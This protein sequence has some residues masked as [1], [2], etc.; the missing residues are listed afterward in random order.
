M[1]SYLDSALAG[2][3]LHIDTESFDRK[4][5]KKEAAGIINRLGNVSAPW[6]TPYSADGEYE[7]L[8]IDTVRGVSLYELYEL[9]ALQGYSVKPGVSN[10][11]CE[12]SWLGQ[13]FYFMDFDCGLSPE[14]TISKFRHCGVEPAFWYRSPSWTAENNK[15]RLVFCDEEETT[16]KVER[17]RVMGVLFWIAGKTTEDELVADKCTFPGAHYYNGSTKGGEYFGDYVFDRKALLEL[18]CDECYDFMPKRC[19]YRDVASQSCSG[20]VASEMRAA[21]GS[22]DYEFSNS[23]N[24]T[25]EDRPRT[26]KQ[27]KNIDADLVMM[28]RFFNLRHWVE[29]EKRAEFVYA[30]YLEAVIRHGYIEGERLTRERISTMLE[31]LTD[32]ELYYIF[33][34]ANAK[35]EIALEEDGV[36]FPECRET[37]AERVNM[38]AEE[39]EII[40]IYECRNRNQRAD[41]RR[42]RKEE[43]DEF[44]RENA[45]LGAREI[46]M[47]LEDMF[48]DVLIGEKQIGRIIDKVDATVE[49]N[50]DSFEMDIFPQNTF[51]LSFSFAPA[52]ETNNSSEEDAVI[53]SALAGEDVLLSGGAGCGKTYLVTNILR[54][55]LADLGKS[56]VATATTGKGASLL[57]GG[58]TVHRL[59][60]IFEENTESMVVPTKL[61]LSLLDVDVVFVDEASMLK[62]KDFEYIQKV[63]N[64]LKQFYNHNIQLILV[65]DFMQ[66]PPVNDKYIFESSEFASWN[67]KVHYLTQI[68]R[69]DDRGFTDMLNS[70]RVA[71]ELCWEYAKALNRERYDNGRTNIA[72]PFISSYRS[73]VNRINDLM[74]ARIEGEEIDLGNIQVK[75]GASVLITGNKYDKA[76]NMKY[77][78][79]LQGVVEGMSRGCLK[80]RLAN[81]NSV[82]VG[83]HQRE[84]GDGTIESYYPVQLGYALTVHQSQ[85]MTL[86]G[87]N[88]NPKSFAPGQLYV[89]LSRV[90]TVDGIYL[91]RPIERR[92]IKVDERALAFDRLMRAVAV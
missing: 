39:A 68:R 29:G 61:M 82:L 45:Y 30:Y 62:A 19:R 21:R 4:P 18:F 72:Y 54:S 24:Y 26:T 2:G 16:N 85:G 8:E 51:D 3:K 55:K 9:T 32:K 49:E 83:K 76:G 89:A 79:G 20:Y 17:D 74:L 43:R 66:L 38:T 27:F 33:N 11:T 1:I 70:L 50:G 63:R 56:V 86:E 58:V 6:L 40:G 37:F 13:Q 67:H 14:E 35:I 47:L 60:Q 69:Q 53:E 84:L 15:H 57:E 23:C 81:G 7:S 36:V 5:T 90:K 64:S 52:T 77:Y 59:F 75:V 31:P 91:T 10:G 25:E 65:G 44:I 48:S 22:R 87:A 88:I 12:E 42:P 80:V 34:Y 92:D 78:N 46:R 73:E 28:N 41:A 71:D